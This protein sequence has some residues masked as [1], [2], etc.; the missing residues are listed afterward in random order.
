MRALDPLS[1][2]QETELYL[3]KLT[4]VDNYRQGYYKD[5]SKYTN[6]SVIL[7]TRS[8]VSV[9]LAG[10][11]TPA[12]SGPVS[13]RS[14][15]C[16]GR[17]WVP[18]SGVLRPLSFPLPLRRPVKGCAE[19][20][21]WLSSH[22]MSDSSPSSLHRQFEWASIMDWL[23]NWMN[24]LLIDWMIDWVIDCLIDWLIDWKREG[25]LTRNGQLD[26]CTELLTEWL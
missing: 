11:P 26:R 22:Y 5:L 23:I 1:H 9:M 21:A 8:L 10:N 24:V 17:F 2:E 20:V 25:W 3:E 15:R 4:Q 19:D 18:P 14:P 13:D 16:D 6:T 7:I 12:C